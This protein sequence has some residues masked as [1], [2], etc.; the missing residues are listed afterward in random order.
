MLRAMF[1]SIALLVVP[2][3]CCCAEVPLN[4]DE[5]AALKYWQAFSQ[6]PKFTDAEVQ[7]LGPESLTMPLDA[8]ARD[9]LAKSEYA[10][11]MMHR[12]SAMPRCHWGISYEDGINVLLPHLQAARL[13]SSVAGLRARLRFADGQSA[14]AVDDVV[15][16]IGLGR[17][18]S[19]DGSLLAV[20]VGY[21]IEQRM[22]E[23][24][25]L[26][27][28]KLDAPMIKD[29][30]ARLGMLPPGGTPAV[31]TLKCEEAT[32]DWFI[33]QVKETNGQE[34][35][36]ELMKPFF[37]SES[38]VPRPD[39]TE[40]ARAFVDECGGNAAGV[41]K[42]AEEVRPSYRLLAKSLE[43][44]LDQFEQ[45]FE[46]EKKRQSGNPVFKVFFPALAKVRQAQARIDVRRALLLAALDVQL[47]GREA[48]K[49]HSDPVAGGSFDYV[50]F[51]GGFEVRSKFKQ[52]DKPL[53]LTVGRH[54]K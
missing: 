26:H 21:A 28:P 2:F 36:F 8:H 49:N 40:K 5:N 29:F 10:L 18:V 54:G 30:K 15:A 23:M 1:L 47:S 46:Q 11:R 52:D 53:V 31:A 35:L 9:I 33:R 43:L 6:L 3:R 13:L 20:L 14:E 48:L 7:K 42:F 51:D 45:Q 25:A 12:G 27:L 44:P 19:G 41:I 50:A 39:V 16:A 17:H 4:P 22:N 34:G 37:I 32:L 38:E 24:L